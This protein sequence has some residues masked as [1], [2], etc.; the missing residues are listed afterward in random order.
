MLVTPFNMSCYISYSEH[1]ILV[2]AY[3]NN[4]IYIPYINIVTNKCSTV[5]FYCNKSQ[6]WEICISYLGKGQKR[7]T[8]QFSML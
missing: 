1:N 8:M 3:L 2:M 4:I 7:I 5:I 6:N